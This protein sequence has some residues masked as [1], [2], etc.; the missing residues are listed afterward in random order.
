VTSFSST[1]PIVQLGGLGFTCWDS[2]ELQEKTLN[3]NLGDFYDEYEAIVWLLFAA[4]VLV[5]IGC[6]LCGCWVNQSLQ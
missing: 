5:I 2:D 3:D 4:M 6:V 1:K